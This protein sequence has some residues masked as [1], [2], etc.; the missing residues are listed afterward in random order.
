MTDTP[1][2]VA[3][4]ALLGLL[5]P[6]WQLVIGVFVLV[7]LALSV[8]RLASRG[9]SRMTTALLVSGGAVVAFA[10]IGVLV[11]GR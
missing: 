1:R 5:H 6:F 2:P 11:Q 8:R 7:M 4:D 9:R 3:A 10:T